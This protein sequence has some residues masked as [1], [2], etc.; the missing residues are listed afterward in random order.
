MIDNWIEYASTEIELPA[1]VWVWPI[2]GYIP[3]N[4]VAT[5]KAKA[6]IRKSLEFLNKTLLTRTFLVGERISLADIV[7]AVSLLRL[8]ERVLDA[9]FR[10]PFGNLNRW[11]L[12]CIN[13][14]EFKAVLG[15]V[16]L[17]EKME[18]APEGAA[19]SG[20]EGK[21]EEQKPKEEKKPAPKKE[22]KKPAP[23]KKEAEPEEEE[24][25]VMIASIV[26]LILDKRE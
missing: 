26:R 22:E 21:K 5:N 19:P 7:V 6:D 1:A 9:P 20:A 23:K 18:V 2:L 17:S 4:S 25:E 16:K 11:F 12:T 13:Q 10:K 14:P 3:N 24:E 15:D 8:Y